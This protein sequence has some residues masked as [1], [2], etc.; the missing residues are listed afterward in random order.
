MASLEEDAYGLRVDSKRSSPYAMNYKFA[1]EAEGQN[2]NEEPNKFQKMRNR[3]QNEG[4]SLVCVKAIEGILEKEKGEAAASANPS[5]GKCYDP[6]ER[7]TRNVTTFAPQ[8]E[9]ARGMSSFGDRRE[10]INPHSKFS[11]GDRRV[12]INPHSKFTEEPFGKFV[13]DFNSRS[14]VQVYKERKMVIE[15]PS[16]RGDWSDVDQMSTVTV[17][18]EETVSLGL[19]AVS[20]PASFTSS[21]ATYGPHWYCRPKYDHPSYGASSTQ[22][23]Y[24]SSMG[25]SS[26]S[27]SN[28]F[29]AE[30]SNWSLLSDYSFDYTLSSRNVSRDWRVAEEGRSQNSGSFHFPKNSEAGVRE[31]TTYKEMLPNPYY[32][33]YGFTRLP[34]NPWQSTLCEGFI[35]THCHL[36][37]LYNKLSFRGSFTKFRKIYSQTFPQEFQGCISDFCDPRTLCNGLWEHLLKEDLVWGAFGCHP[38]FAQYYND[39]YE[40][41]ILQ[42]LRHPKAVA[43]GEMG[44]DYSHKCTTSI[45]K[46]RKVF[47]RQLQLAVSLKK[48]LVIHCREADKDLLYIMKKFVP[49][50][51]KIHRHCFTGSYP[52]VEPMLKH[53][54]NMSVGFTAV[55]TYSSAWEVRDAL[56]KIPLDRIVVETDAPYF[57]PRWVSKS[58]CKYT[59]PGLALHT[60]QE[61]ARLKGQPLSHVLSTLLKN[62]SC[63]YSL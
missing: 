54:P 28:T 19:P 9:S 40:K 6:V 2:K 17:P 32:E 34:W 63:L 61:M 57:L 5:I 39:C 62:T 43:F 42:A 14:V 27:S 30:R 26:S 7:P 24:C 18:Q 58:I 36:D 45:P 47:E 35:D 29:Q 15:S 50:D 10:S 33:G 21:Y 37:M 11:F 20:E 22:P 31:N 49:F 56:K 4:S 52:D 38:H 53:F 44:L 16:S 46:Q 41:T 60:V 23:S 55:L 12:S 51:Y 13:D 1:A 3:F 25:G 59:H 8:M 48:P